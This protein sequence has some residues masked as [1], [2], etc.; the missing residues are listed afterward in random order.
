MPLTL[1]IVSEH[2]EIVGDD[3]VR[4]FREEGGTIGRALENDWIL[5]DP[6]KYISG[7]HATIDFKG[8]SYFLADT[9]SNGTYINDDY[10]PLGKGNPRRLFNGDRLRMGDFEI[11]VRV[12]E[13]EGLELPPPPKPTVVPDNIE[14]LV[15]EEQLKTGVTLL[16]EEEI[17]GDDEF[18]SALFGH[19]RLTINAPLDDEPE[20]EPLR[21]EL[22]AP[23]PARPAEITADDVFDSF[24]DGL[25]LN[26]TDFH[27]DVDLAEAMQNAG[28]V[29]REFVAGTDKLIA[30][31]AELKNAFRLEQTT[32]LPRHNN[33]LKLSQNT[34][35][36]IKQLLIGREGEYLGPRDAVRE[37]CR[38]LLFH[39]DAF[40]EA[41]TS[42]FI[43]FA[44]RFDPDELAEAFNRMLDRKPIIGA[45][46]QLK[47][48]QL[49]TELY[50]VMVERGGSRFPQ[51]FAEE[52]VRAYEREIANAKR[53]FGPD[54]PRRRAPD[55]LEEQDFEQDVAAEISDSIVDEPG[56]AS[57]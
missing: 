46:G 14:Q 57:N 43:E 50:P 24:L 21:D 29:L 25:G 42:A 53:G 11:T 22:P 2:R 35:D 51:M 36:S 38:D 6:D 12:D 55:M 19:G 7:R 31:R 10:E 20:A 45:L 40:L 49:Y 48:W 41:M 13:G 4:V 9:S 52:F 23:P 54:S 26:R 44:D 32:V 33:P 15:P 39:Q 28:E 17:T 30:S 27:P 5:P 1:E 47:Y 3:A 34:T 56:Q 18:Q 8:G 16:D 37:I